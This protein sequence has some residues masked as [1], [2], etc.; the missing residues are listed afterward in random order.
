MNEMGKSEEKKKNE[1][2]K[3]REKSFVGVVWSTYPLPETLRMVRTSQ[4]SK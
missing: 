3:V 4:I 1:E 2:S